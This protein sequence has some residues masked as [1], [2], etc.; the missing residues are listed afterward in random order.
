MRFADELGELSFLEF[1][2]EMAS[3]EE[4]QVGLFRTFECVCDNHIAI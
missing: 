1:L 4:S 2:E 3:F